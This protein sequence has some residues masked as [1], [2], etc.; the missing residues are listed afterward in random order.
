MNAL[1]TRDNIYHIIDNNASL[2]TTTKAQYRK[3]L[4][5][6][7]AT[8]NSLT[9][10][11]AISRYAATISKSSKAFLKSAIR[12]WTEAMSK[13]AKSQAD[14]TIENTSK[15]QATLWH[16]ESIND[17]IQVPIT[18]GIKA[19]T[20]LT[21]AEVRQ[22]VSNCDDTLQGKRDRVVLS[23]LVGSGL[24][25]EELASLTF[26]NIKQQ[27]K[28]MV[29]EVTGKGSKSR[30]IPISEKLA[31]ILKTWHELVGNG[32]IVRSVGVSKELGDSLSPVQIFRIVRSYGEKIGKP[33][34]AAHDL[35]RTYAQ[36]GYEAGIPI[37]Q[38]SKLLGHSNVA[39][40]QRYLNLDLDLETTASDFIPL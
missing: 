19:H 11:E 30:V 32:F 17:A 6:Y 13:G 23:L 7:L 37:T 39:T 40:T 28:R 38:I 18:K 29:L 26:D 20:W 15:I 33:E 34:L 4:S 8:G 12:L 36:L 21:Q 27:G 16:L 5:N 10:S 22:L 14:G 9:D 3:A 1:A 2:A 35:R 24:R 31:S 25:R